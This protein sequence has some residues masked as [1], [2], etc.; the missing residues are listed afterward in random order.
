M[1]LNQIFNNLASAFEIV[2]S[3]L[4]F[5]L[6][7]LAVKY[8]KKSWKEQVRLDGRIAAREMLFKDINWNEEYIPVYVTIANIG[9]KAIENVYVFVDGRI[10]KIVPF[11]LA[12]EKVDLLVAKYSV[13]G[14]MTCWLDGVRMPPRQGDGTDLRL[15]K[16]DVNSNSVYLTR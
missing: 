2:D 15:P 9:E 4:M 13:T 3:I 11:I 7:T 12:N 6:T 16:I 8:A 10:F 1:I 5:I 14:H